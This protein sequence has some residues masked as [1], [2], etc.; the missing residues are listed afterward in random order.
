MN[1]SLKEQLE[2]LWCATGE[3]EEP[4]VKPT[5]MSRNASNDINPTQDRLNCDEG[6]N[7]R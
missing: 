3:V 4:I 7:G 5:E 1:K 2:F 6:L